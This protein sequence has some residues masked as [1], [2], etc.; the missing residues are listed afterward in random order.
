MYVLRKL[1]SAEAAQSGPD[2][3]YG[4]SVCPR[5]SSWQRC[6]LDG[7]CLVSFNYE[8]ML[9]RLHGAKL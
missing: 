5:P 3:N 1:H 6:V 7:C 9:L 2:S 4:L 8:A